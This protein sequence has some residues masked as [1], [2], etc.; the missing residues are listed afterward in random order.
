MSNSIWCDG[1]HIL[2]LK[3]SLFGAFHDGM[4]KVIDKERINISS[5]VLKLIE[6]LDQDITGIGFASVDIKK[7]LFKRE[8]ALDFAAIIKK[9]LEHQE[10]VQCIFTNDVSALFQDLYNEVVNFAETLPEGKSSPID[11]HIFESYKQWKGKIEE[12][13]VK[14][15]DEL[16]QKRKNVVFFYQGNPFNPIEMQ[17][18]AK[19]YNIL[20]NA[21]KCSGIELTTELASL[22]NELGSCCYGIGLDFASFLKNKDDWLLFIALAKGKF[23]AIQD[24]EPTLFSKE[25]KAQ[26]EQFLENLYESFQKNIKN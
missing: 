25:E 16:L 5:A 1:K 14:L 21:I 23:D 15:Y 13:A 6:A 26:I 4:L 22:I 3:N 9:V 12:E 17:T 24:N 11:A 8:D 20:S 10:S 2:R 19:F 7:F 18:F